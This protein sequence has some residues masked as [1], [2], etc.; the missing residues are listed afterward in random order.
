MGSSKSGVHN[1]LGYIYLQRNI[2][3]SEGNIYCTAATK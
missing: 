3:H 1:L 2:C